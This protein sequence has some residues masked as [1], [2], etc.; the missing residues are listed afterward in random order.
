MAELIRKQTGDLITLHSPQLEMFPRLR[1]AYFTR[2]GGVS[3]G[4][5]ESMNFR[6]TGGDDRF[7]TE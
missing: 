3:Q 7:K 4:V 1:H 6:L 5:F 2:H